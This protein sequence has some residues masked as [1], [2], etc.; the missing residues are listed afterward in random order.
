[1]AGT[2]VR[3]IKGLRLRT[4]GDDNLTVEEFLEQDRRGDNRS[5]NANDSQR[6][7]LKPAQNNERDSGE[8]LA[9]GGFPD[10]S[11]VLNPKGDNLHQI[12]K[13]EKINLSSPINNQPS[14]VTG[15]EEKRNNPPLNLTN[16][17]NKA[18]NSVTQKQINWQSYPYN[19]SNEKKLEERASLVKEIILSCGTSNE[20]IE[21]ENEGKISER[22]ITW[23]KKNVLTTAEREL[24]LEIEL[25]RQGNL[26]SIDSNQEV[27]HYEFNDVMESI[28]FAASQAGRS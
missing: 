22:E 1:M 27:V 14:K 19:S 10:L 23:L 25:T 9:V 2:S 17:E 20:L 3:I 4:P 8:I 12:K 28:S 16:V 21:L 7:N 11:K 24:V 26:F 13:E 18:V 15:G 6:D 5:D